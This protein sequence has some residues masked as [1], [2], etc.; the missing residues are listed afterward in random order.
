[1]TLYYLTTEHRRFALEL[2][3]LE[4]IPADLSAK[5]DALDNSIAGKVRNRVAMRREA[6]AAAEAFRAEAKRFTEMARTR[7][8]DAEWLATDTIRCMDLIGIDSI[9]T[10]IGTVS[11][12]LSPRPTI[13][14]EGVGDVPAEFSRIK[15]EL[16]GNK[17]Y[18]AW[19][20]GHLPDGF[21][22]ERGRFLR[23]G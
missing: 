6:L 10:D 8:R 2:A 7:E 18:G 4:E 3:D 21:V 11:V 14:W 19:K 23:V 9:Y 22:A 15:V 16:D 13:R 12:R 5:L 20:D 1:M 17:V